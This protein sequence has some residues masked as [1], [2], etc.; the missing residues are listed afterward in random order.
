MKTHNKENKECDLFTCK[1]EA[2]HKAKGHS[3][4]DFDFGHFCTCQPDTHKC[5]FQTLHPTGKTMCIEC[6][7]LPDK[8]EGWEKEFDKRLFSNTLE[9]DR[10]LH[11]S[12]YC[13]EGCHIDD[14]EMKEW[15]ATLLAQERARVGRKARNLIN[16]KITVYYRSKFSQDCR[17]GETEEEKS[18]EMITLSDAR[19]V[20]EEVCGISETRA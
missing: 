8:Q 13:K 19:K 4:P 16:D 11:L 5:D 2:E 20:I 1:D 10:W 6:G 18:T 15:I 12:S 14:I 7:E 9:H 3:N 17:R